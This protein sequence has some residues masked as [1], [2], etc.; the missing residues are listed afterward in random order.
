MTR[1][2]YISHTSIGQYNARM[3]EMLRHDDQLEVEPTE[4]LTP[5]RHWSVRDFD[6]TLIELTK[7][8]SAI[9]GRDRPESIDLQG[10]PWRQSM[11]GMWKYTKETGFESGQIAL[12]DVGT[13][14]I[15]MGEFSTGDDASVNLIKT[16][17]Q[18]RE[19]EQVPV[20]MMHCHPDEAMNRHGFTDVDFISFLA[21]TDI[22][23]TIVR[24]GDRNA[25]LAMK[26][27]VTP[28]LSPEETTVRIRETRDEFL[29]PGSN[30]IT[31][32]PQFNKT[33]CVEF[34]LTLY[35]MSPESKG[36][37]KRIEVTS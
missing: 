19:A 9:P 2:G 17:Q 12:A 35:H 34:G 13:G 3:D 6:S 25:L 29:G 32:L 36:V 11:D 7:T 31:A 26:T 14:A 15:V 37:F 30:P 22:Q 16:R 8:K 33:V 23:A 1:Y 24:Y 18:G 28:D 10:E 27:S 4:L 20:V 5:D 21:D